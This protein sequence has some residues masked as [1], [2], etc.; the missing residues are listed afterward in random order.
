MTDVDLFAVQPRVEVADYL[1]A[2]AFA[3]KHR[4]L[5]ARIDRMR[6][7]LPGPRR[8]A[9]AVWPEMVGTFLGLLGQDVTGATTTDQVMRR[10]ALRRLPVLLATMA[11]HRTGRTTPALLTLLAPEVY[12]VYVDTFAAIARDHDLWVVAGSAL[13][14][15]NRF[16]DGDRRFAADG[17]RVYNTSY[18]F[19]PD[20]RCVLVTRKVNLVPTQED[21]L[22]LSA[23]AVSELAATD[24]P[25]GRLGTLICYDG[26]AEPHTEHEPRWAPCAGALDALG[27]DVLAQPSANAW[28]WDAPWAFNA[29]GEHLLRRE[30]WFTEGM[31]A[32]L[33]GLRTVRWVVNPQ[34]VGTV[35]DNVFEAPSLILARRDD[36]GVDVLAQSADP[37]GEDVLHARVG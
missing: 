7:A 14:P 20:G 22:H 13:L 4:V 32:Q 35:L 2:E 17:A 23:G 28:A 31:A 21:V 36:G 37:R 33:G 1:S 6:D 3:A 24:T 10:V 34:L 27:V 30:Q 8:P 5:A 16:P 19:A 9:L 29:P 25:F 11:R 15:R 18:A 12:R 26:F